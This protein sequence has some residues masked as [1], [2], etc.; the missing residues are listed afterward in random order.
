L[1]FADKAILIIH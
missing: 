1:F